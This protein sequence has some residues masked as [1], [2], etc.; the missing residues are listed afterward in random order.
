MFLTKS[1]LNFIQYK[2]LRLDVPQISSRS[3]LYQLQPIGNS[4]LLTENLTSFISRLADSH[5]VSTG[6]LISQIVADFFQKK[7]IFDG[8]SRGIHKVYNRTSAIN[9]IGLMAL[10]WVNTIETLTLVS[11]LQ[12]LTLL[13]FKDVFPMRNLLRQSRAW[14]PICYEEW[15]SRGQTIYEPLNWVLDAVRVC[16]KHFSYLVTACPTCKRQVP[17][18]DWSS[19]PGYCSK[20][21]QWLGSYLENSPGLKFEDNTIQ[22]EIWVAS[23]VASLLSSALHKP[24]RQIVTHALSN[25]IKLITDGNVAEFARMLRL[26]KNTVWLWKTGKNLPPLDKLL[27]ICYLTQIPLINFL[28]NNIPSSQDLDVRSVSFTNP[29]TPKLPGRFFDVDRVFSLLENELLSHNYPPPSAK[30]IASRL[31]YDIRLLREHFPEI[32]SAISRK[33]ASYRKACR[34]RRVELLCREIQS[35][36][37]KLYGEGVYPTQTKV[38]AYLTKPGCF[39]ELAARNALYEVHKI[40]GLGKL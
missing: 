8:Q 20:C 40:L 11:Q 1:E 24:S 36:A 34:S 35:T 18:L 6:S 31:D 28:N 22:W 4:E 27:R 15:F 21:N 7:Y 29:D 32:C 19:R 30:E 2:Q 39:R 16:H 3:C 25:C 17:W 26:P 38:S 23:N 12:Q 14:C 37:F 10:D 5:G 13:N 9:G 33:H